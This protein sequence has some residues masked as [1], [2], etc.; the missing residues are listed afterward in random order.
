MQHDDRTK[1]QSTHAWP[2][3][4]LAALAVS[5]ACLLGLGAL[6]TALAGCAVAA[7]AAAGGAVG[8]VA[9][10]EAA[11]DEVRDQQRSDDEVPHE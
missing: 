3:Y 4:V 2:R 7:G 10:H 5:V 9:G 8:Y 6:T 1:Y 11:K